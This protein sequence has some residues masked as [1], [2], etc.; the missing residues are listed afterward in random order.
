VQ[1]TAGDVQ[2]IGPD[3]GETA[4][5]AHIFVDR[6]YGDGVRDLRRFFDEYASFPADGRSTIGRYAQMYSQLMSRGEDLESFG[7]A[8]RQL[9]ELFPCKH[10]ATRLKMAVVA[11]P[12]NRRFYR[13]LPD[14]MV[15]RGMIVDNPSNSFDPAT[16]DLPSRMSVLWKS[17][18]QAA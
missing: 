3:E 2:I 16:L 10:Q 9:A 13:Q 7:T 17:E 15:L 8:I 5:W 4:S 6:L 14:A 11:D 12:Q 1:R 18:P